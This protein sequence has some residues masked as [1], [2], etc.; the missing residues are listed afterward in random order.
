[1][2]NII[3]LSTVI[4]ACFLVQ[5]CKKQISEVRYAGGTDPVLTVSSTDPQVLSIANKNKN[6][7]SFSWT[8]PNYQLSTGVS[9]QDVS[10]TVQID[11]SSKFTTPD[12]SETTIAKDLSATFTVGDLNKKLLAMNLQP[13]VAYNLNI[14]LRSTLGIS[15]PLYSNVIVVTVTPYLDAAVT[16]PGTPPFFTDGKL[17]LVGSATAGGWDNPVPLPT[18]EFT[19]IDATHYTITISLVGGQ[20]YLLLPVNGDWSVKYGNACGSNSCNAAAGD[21][22]KQG[23]DNIKGPSSGGMHTINVNFVSGKFTV[24]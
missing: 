4:I 6:A 5:A 20:E 2:K 17:Y 10:Y 15:V 22:F 1:M 21:N 12:L 3:K 11:T 24:N 7:I 23:G 18:Q 13:G 16:P 19:R 14:R 8:N 9:S